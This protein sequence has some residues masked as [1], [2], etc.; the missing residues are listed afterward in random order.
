[1]GTA[2]RRTSSVL[3][4]GSRP[5]TPGASSSSGRNRSG[6]V[7][8]SVS[9][10]SSVTSRPSID[11]AAPPIPPSSAPSVIMMPSPIAESPSREAAAT[12]ETPES[13]VG[14][15][16]LAQVMTAPTEASSPA[17]TVEASKTEA[18][19]PAI[20]ESANGPTAFTEEPEEM[21]LRG[22]PAAESSG[23]PVVDSEVLEVPKSET[24]AVPEAPDAT[25]SEA[26]PSYFEIPAHP[27]TASLSDSDS[28]KKAIVD[29]TIGS[30][31][32]DGEST[33]DGM[34]SDQTT[35]RPHGP[36]DTENASVF[37]AFS[38]MPTPAPA[39][40][41]DED[42]TKTTATAETPPANEFIPREPEQ[43]VGVIQMPIP[44]I[45]DQP[46]SVSL[47]SK[48]PEAA[49]PVPEIIPEII[50]IE[51]D[52]SQ[53]AWASQP[54]A[55]KNQ[56]SLGR[57]LA[58][59]SVQTLEDPFADP[60]PSI[61]IL[62]TG[63]VLPPPDINAVQNQGAPTLQNVP[64]LV[65]PVPQ[66]DIVLNRS[67]NDVAGLEHDN[68]LRFHRETNETLPLLGSQVPPQTSYLQ[69]NTLQPEAAHLN[70][71]G[72]SGSTSSVGW[73]QIKP[74]PSHTSTPRL[75]HLGWIE[76][77]LPDATSYYSH[78]TLRVTTDV[79]LRSITKLDAITAY[80]ESRR[81]H[82]GS[83]TPPG[84]E[85]WLKEGA[86]TN[87]KSTRKKRGLGRTKGFVP[88]RQ[89]VDHRKRT[90]TS[91]PVWDAQGDG[92]AMRHQ[93]GK[94]VEDSLDMQY[95][96]WAFMEDHPAH[97]SLPQNARTDAMDVLNWSWTDRLLPS[98]RQ[99]PPPFTQAECQELNNLLRSYG[100]YSSD[101][102][103]QSLLHT[104]MVSRILMRVGV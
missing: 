22:A 53:E 91:D 25:V 96:Y 32:N 57:R 50:P 83:G 72:F 38:N 44:Q 23:E 61:Q 73:P 39:P 101:A 34:L 55:Q 100:E 65:L 33:A 103:I 88:I 7:A 99:V 92:S 30:T 78:P 85:L 10:T 102:G 31:T 77:T 1:M 18:Q 14:P 66:Q 9:D 11:T 19:E 5:N 95:R 89:W 71:S 76:Y 27:P 20:I 40:V 74:A 64:A 37:Y 35:P 63:P 79:D 75:H 45:V 87:G 98:E 26:A 97:V 56:D 58:D 67:V 54:D 84:F 16:P 69:A 28:L 42:P 15:T 29:N 82:D 80:L 43:D 47:L 36:A 41:P 90:V 4:L 94:I 8:T 51:V 62:T 68:Q 3:T 49:L 12:E 46:K 93:T 48:D 81:S 86:V 70:V 17:E 52:S 21:S 6:S 24:W 2:M 59:G 13:K 104:R 60:V